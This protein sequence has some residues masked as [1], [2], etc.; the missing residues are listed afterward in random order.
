MCAS[1]PLSPVNL[2]DPLLGGLCASLGQ[3]GRSHEKI[4]EVDIVH[5]MELHRRLE[6]K[7]L[8]QL[9]STL[10]ALLLL[11]LLSTQDKNKRH[12]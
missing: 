5:L 11:Q 10:I 6:V 4:P 12:S 2:V 8:L 7:A 3:G 9:I 1:R